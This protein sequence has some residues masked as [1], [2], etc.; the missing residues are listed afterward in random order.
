MSEYALALL[1]NLSAFLGVKATPQPSPLWETTVEWS[2]QSGIY[3][4]EARTDRLP[5]FCANFPDRILIFPSVI[6]GAQ[7]VFADGHLIKSFGDPSFQRFRSFY[8]AP[9]LSCRMLEKSRMITWRVHSYSGYFAR[10][11][12]FPVL[13]RA[14]DV[15]NLFGEVFHAGAA[16]ILLIMGLWV[17]IIFHR[18]I[19]PMVSY[20]LLLGHTCSTLYFLMSCA[21]I[22]GLEVSMLTAH[23]LADLGLFLGAFGLLNSFRLEGYL[24]PLQMRLYLICMVLVGAMVVG[25]SDGDTI[26][27]GTTLMFIPSALALGRILWQVAIRYV[28]GRIGNRLIFQSISLC[29]YAICSTSDMLV[30]MG[31][32]EGVPLYALGTVGAMAFMCLAVNQRIVL[33]YKERDNLRMNLA[34]E[35]KKKTAELE[36]ALVD[37]KTTQAELIQSSNLASLGTLAAG[38]AH[39]INNSLNYVHGALP[40]LKNLVRKKMAGEFDKKAGVLF[41]AMETGLKMTFEI[42]ESLRRYTGLNH[43]PLKPFRVKD[44]LDSVLV[45]MKGPIGKGIELDLDVDPDLMIEGNMAGM[46]QILTNLISNAIDAMQGKGRLRIRVANANGVDEIRIRVEDSGCGMEEEVRKRIFEPFY[47]TKEVG[48]GTGIGL[49]LVKKEVDFHNGHISVDSRPGEGTSF[50]LSFP[51]WKPGQKEAA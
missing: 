23:R 51:V 9:R 29:W 49:H 31:I 33:T 17:H 18:K 26:Q 10:F 3:V 24:G 46:S 22:F 47:T 39:E 37:L 11:A 27:L 38:I 13:R 12:H 36:Q 20:S 15:T 48:K 30:V 28:D 14:D 5:E 35:V 25:A 45:I 40:P 16:M 41:G 8:G 32:I 7:Q 6:H 34:S 50:T 19:P 4:Y 21:G 42:I 1:L 43:N 2:R 44:V